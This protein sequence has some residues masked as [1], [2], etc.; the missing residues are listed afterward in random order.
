LA[1]P[2]IT[3]AAVRTLALAKRVFDAGVARGSFGR[4]DRERDDR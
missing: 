4:P 3:N 1:V 2:G